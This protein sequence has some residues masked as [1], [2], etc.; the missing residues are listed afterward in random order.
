LI[1]FIPKN[2]DS[3]FRLC[4]DNNRFSLIESED[5]TFLAELEVLLKSKSNFQLIVIHRS[6]SPEGKQKAVELCL[7]YQKEDCLVVMDDLLLNDINNQCWNM[8]LSNP[9]VTISFDLIHCGIFCFN[10]KLSKKNYKYYM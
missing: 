3:A 9:N 7:L 4:E 8:I 5:D 2:I 10:N 6:L 1:D